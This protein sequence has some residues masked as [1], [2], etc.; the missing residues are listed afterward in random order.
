MHVAN[1]NEIW[2]LLL[3]ISGALAYIFE[4]TRSILNAFLCGIW[5]T[6]WNMLISVFLPKI[7]SFALVLY[8][9]L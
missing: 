1:L 8:L 2:P 3:V 5:I 6:H 4:M 7:C 9:V